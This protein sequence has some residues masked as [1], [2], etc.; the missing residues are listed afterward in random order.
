MNE[1]RQASRIR[2]ALNHSLKDISPAASRRLEAARRVAGDGR[3]RF[4][5]G[6]DSLPT[7]YRAQGA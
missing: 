7:T 6:D 3:L 4:G 2:Q 1:I 5:V